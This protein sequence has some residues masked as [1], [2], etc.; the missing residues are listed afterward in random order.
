MAAVASFS[1]LAAHEVDQQNRFD[2]LGQQVD[3]LRANGDSRQ[4]EQDARIQRMAQIIAA[5]ENID[6]GAVTG[7][8]LGD[9]N[10]LAGVGSVEVS[11]ETRTKFE[12]ATVLLTKRLKGTTDAWQEDCTATIVDSGQEKFIMSAQH[13]LIGDIN[14]GNT[15]GKGG[16]GILNITNGDHYEYGV[17]TSTDPMAELQNRQPDAV[18]R[19]AAI[20][21]TGMSD[22]AL[23]RFDEGQGQNLAA[24]PLESFVS[25]LNPPIAGQQV[26]LFGRPAINSAQPAKMNGIYLG[27]VGGLE[28]SGGRSEQLDLVA[29]K[30]SIVSE[31]SCMYGASGSSA[32]FS[33]GELA[34]PL[35]IRNGNDTSRT[36]VEDGEA[37]WRF[38]LENLTG[39]NLDDYPTICGFSVPSRSTIPELINALDNPAAYAP[40]TPRLQIETK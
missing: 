12:A 7:E 21:M 23:L 15:S 37:L 32:Q 16:G 28:V 3:D 6:V 1:V 39:L 40:Y 20:D 35:S 10:D 38:K 9:I 18:A 5:Q 19:S 31:D 11:L 13:C 2:A 36:H 34:G 27:R 17:F 14:G 24:I 25:S 4:S 8:T 26:A 29:I 30:P 22:T 33:N